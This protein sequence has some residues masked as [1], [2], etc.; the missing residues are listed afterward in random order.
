[1]TEKYDENWHKEMIERI[2][3]QY[4]EFKKQQNATQEE[5][6][7]ETSTAAATTSAAETATTSAATAP[8]SSSNWAQYSSSRLRNVTDYEDP[9]QTLKIQN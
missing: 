1:M 6:R 2:N 4:A 3:R 9:N 7:D 8:S 5:E